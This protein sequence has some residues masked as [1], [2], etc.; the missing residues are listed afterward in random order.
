MEKALKEC[1]SY[2]KNNRGYDKIFQQMR[3]KW[4]SYGKISGNI[5]VNNPTSEDLMKSEKY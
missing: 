2:F 3:E 4:I 1:V 5:I